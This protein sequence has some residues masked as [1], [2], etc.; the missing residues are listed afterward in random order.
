MKRLAPLTVTALLVGAVIFVACG[1]SKSSPSPA[2]TTAGTASTPAATGAR[3]STRL[4]VMNQNLLHG[5]LNEDPTAEPFDRVGDR[6]RLVGQALAAAKPDIATLQEINIT[7]TGGYPDIRAALRS[8]LPDYQQTFG[9]I[10]GEPINQGALGQMTLTKLPIISTENRHIQ[11]VRAVHRVTVRTAAGPVDIFNAHLDGT[12]DN[13]PQFSVN[14]IN[15]VLAFVNETRS[16][17]P[18]ILAGDFNARPD[19]PSIKVLLNAGY[20]DALAK[21]GNA[22]CA[23]KGDPGCTNS[24]MPLVDN[25]SQNSDQRIDYIF[26]LPGN[27]VAATVTEASLFDNKPVDVGG[28]HTLWP[29][30]HIGVR[31]VIELT[32]K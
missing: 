31:A 18:A 17:G 27:S 19:S 8:A 7:A 6:V 9:S 21:A 5:M 3:S 29:S 24:N 32:P 30:D 12:N 26:V 23:K 16:G 2:A 22:T 20:I 13:D 15:K 4:L 14:E 11:S 10:A 28:G 25:P 1:G